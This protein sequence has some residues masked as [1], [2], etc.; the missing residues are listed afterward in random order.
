MALTIRGSAGVVI[1]DVPVP[2]VRAPAV[3]AVRHPVIASLTSALHRFNEVEEWCTVSTQLDTRTC[4]VT[5][6]TPPWPARKTLVFGWKEGP[7]PW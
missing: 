2:V 1:R 4:H 6:R 3:I 7:A 5:L